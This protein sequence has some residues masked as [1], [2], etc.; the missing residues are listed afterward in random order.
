MNRL[1]VQ[2]E[3]VSVV[4]KA[5]VY[6]EGGVVSHTVLFKDGSKKT[7]GLIRPGTYKFNTDVAEQMDIIGGMCR[8]KLPNSTGWVVQSAGSSFQ[9]PAKSSFEVTMETG[10]CEYICSFLK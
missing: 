10:L 8:V 7:L 3:N 6:F 1:F 9:V 5:N 2:F 4:C